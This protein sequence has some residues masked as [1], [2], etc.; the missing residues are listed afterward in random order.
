VLYIIKYRIDL[1]LS[2]LFKEAPLVS[3]VYIRDQ[4][5]RYYY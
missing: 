2:I 3:K 4:R 1:K 5:E